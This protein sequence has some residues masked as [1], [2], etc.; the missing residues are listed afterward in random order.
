MDQTGIAL[1]SSEATENHLRFSKAN[2][3]ARRSQLL[4]AGK[5]LARK[6]HEMKGYG[7]VRILG[8]PGWMGGLSGY[9]SCT[10]RN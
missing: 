6:R 1:A 5:A 9:M 10:D 2:H 7:V 4:P 3:L 8:R